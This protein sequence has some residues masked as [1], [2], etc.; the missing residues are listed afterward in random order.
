MENRILHTIRKKHPLI[1]NMTNPVS[2]HLQANGLLAIGASPIMAVAAQEMEE[3]ANVCDGLLLNIGTLTCSYANSA[4]IAAMYYAQRGKRIVLDPVGVG[5]SA[6][7]RSVFDRLMRSGRITVIRCNAGELAAIAQVPWN[8]KGVDAGEGKQD[9]ARIARQVAT[10]YG[11]IVGVSGETDFVSD[12]YEVAELHGGHAVMPQV[13]GSGCLLSSVVTAAIVS[14][15]GSCYTS[16]CDAMQSYK[17]AGAEAAK[18][19]GG[20][21]DF[22]G[23]FLNR[24][25]VMSGGVL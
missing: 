3:L 7:R 22:Q 4:E 12:G 21:G 10:Q 17:D 15:D 1:H 13:T 9:I 19:I 5:V 6:F 8:N 11:C 2:A 16:V 14:A 18:H 25:F 20:P 23:S 24:L